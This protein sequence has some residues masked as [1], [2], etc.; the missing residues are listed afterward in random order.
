MPG[1]QRVPDRSGLCQAQGSARAPATAPGGAPAA[2]APCVRTGL[3]RREP[4]PRAS[5]SKFGYLSVSECRRLSPRARLLRADAGPVPTIRAVGTVIGLMV[6]EGHKAEA[7]QDEVVAAPVLRRAEVG[8]GSEGLVLGMGWNKDKAAPFHRGDYTVEVSINDYLDI[9][10]PH[11]EEPLPERMERYI[12]YMVNY[13]GHASCDHRQRGFKR[14]ECNRPDSPNGPLKFS[15]KF[16]LFTPFSLG[17]E[18]RPGHEYYYISASPPN[19]V[20]RPCLKL[21]VYVRPTNDSLYESPEPIFTSN[22]SCCSLRVPHAV[23][24]VV[25]VVWTLLAS[26]TCLGRSPVWRVGATGEK[27]A[28]ILLPREV[29]IFA[30]CQDIVPRMTDPHGAGLSPLP[31]SPSPGRLRHPTFAR[32]RAEPRAAPRSQGE[33]DASDGADGSV[34]ADSFPARPSLRQQDVA[35]PAAARFPCHPSAVGVWGW[36]GMDGHESPLSAWWGDPVPTARATDVTAVPVGP[37]G[38][39]ASS[40]ANWTQ[41]RGAPGMAGR[42]VERWRWPA[43]TESTGDGWLALGAPPGAGSRRAGLAQQPGSLQGC[44]AGAGAG[45]PVRGRADL[46]GAGG[47]CR[48]GVARGA[49]FPPPQPSALHRVVPPPDALGVREPPR[50]GPAAA[51]GT[52]AALPTVAPLSPR[53][54]PASPEFRGFVLRHAA[55]V[56][57]VVLMCQ[58]F[59][60]T[61]ALAAPEVNSPVVPVV[62]VSGLTEIQ[63][64][65]RTLH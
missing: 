62:G 43:G 57:D 20:D 56:L 28:R 14:W 50:G 7:S 16:Q 41:P 1:L 55:F 37:W 47:A 33:T 49:G 30:P 35:V 19:M 3:A 65:L 5:V 58:D 4:P 31:P 42:H 18:F 36:G 54:L 6:P 23:L 32:P 8:S 60:A 53:L 40:K 29:P 25:P 61:W 64:H 12:L 48:P 51:C 59:R 11:Y 15:E 27:L 10:C 52:I 22:N 17:F 24:V 13:E 2:T 39:S 44:L 38:R 63:L 21:K 34:V 45:A 26:G 46:A 9:Y